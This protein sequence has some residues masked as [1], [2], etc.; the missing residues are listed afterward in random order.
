MLP[1]RSHSKNS[2]SSWIRKDKRLAIYL[3]DRFTCLYCGKDLHG[4][5]PFEITLDHLSPVGGN[6]ESNL[7]CACRSCNCY[8]RKNRPWRQYA[9][10]NAIKRI[11]R[12]TRRSLKKYRILAK[13][14][15]AGETGVDAVTEKLRS[16][17]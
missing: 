3:R 7:I 17:V 15:L 1:A 6:S 13:A 14:I 4:V 12:H 11:I 9:T 8:V 5:E 10:G 16:K 2:G